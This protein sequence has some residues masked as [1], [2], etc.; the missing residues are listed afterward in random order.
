M[1]TLIAAG[2]VLAEFSA[3]LIIAGVIIVRSRGT[4][5]TRLAWLVVILALPVFGI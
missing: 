5:A 3:R 1:G 2:L 4:P